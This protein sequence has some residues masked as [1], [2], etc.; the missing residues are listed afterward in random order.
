MVITSAMNPL[1]LTVIEL[2][3]AT[4]IKEQIDALNK[5]LRGIFGAST[6]SGPASKRTTSAAGK[7][8][9]AAKPAQPSA[10]TAAKAQKNTVS[11]A[12]RAKLSAKLKAFW[13]AKRAGKK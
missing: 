8:N 9:I 11:A 6:K 12:T 3:R 10:K 7:K 2:K 1:D 4:A 13:A 5:D